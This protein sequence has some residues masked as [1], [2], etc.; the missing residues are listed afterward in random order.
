M[1]E[2]RGKRGKRKRGNLSRFS[3]SLISVGEPTCTKA[4][5][6]HPRSHH[7]QIE[8]EESF[9]FLSD[10]RTLNSLV[11]SRVLRRIKIRERHCVR[12][13]GPIYRSS[14]TIQAWTFEQET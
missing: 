12:N 1:R 10:R 11:L 9:Q 14:L 2:K 4:P 8:E 7:P 3:I 13:H 5:Q 6:L